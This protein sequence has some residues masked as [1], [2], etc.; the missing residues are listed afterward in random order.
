MGI[1]NYMYFYFACIY[2]HIDNNLYI[3][4]N[5]LFNLATF[6][7]TKLTIFNKPDVRNLLNVHNMFTF[8]S[9]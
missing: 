2:V 6:A 5:N 3:H 7:F 1:T 4:T 9:A 8:H